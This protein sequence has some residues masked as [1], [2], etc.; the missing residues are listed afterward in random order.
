MART[1]DVFIAGVMA[2]TITH[3]PGGNHRFDY[4][5]VYQD[6]AQRI[7]LSQSLPLTQRR[8]GMRP[9]SNWMWGLLPD[10]E[11]TLD[12]WARR[13]RVSARNPFALLGA[14]GEDCPG[15]VQL[16]H[17]GTGIAAGG[18]VAWITKAGLER[19]I[20]ELLKD[21]G[22]GRLDDDRGQFSLA[23]AQAK[24]ALL[25]EGSRW[26]VPSGRM[27]T[28]HILKPESP[29]F[30]GLAANEHFCLELARAA[31]LPAVR[32]EVLHT[33]NASVFV[34]E[35]YD[36]FRQ[37]GSKTILRLHQ[38][39]C[40]QALGI[41]PQKKYQ[42]EGGPGIPEIMELLRFSKAPETDRGRF[43]R[44]QAFNF[45][46]AGTDAH[47]KNFAILYEPSGAYRLM[48]LYDVI[49]FLPYHTR[50]PQL[51]LAMT[52]GGRRHPSE[53]KPHHWERTAERCGYPA[54]RMQQS[55]RELLETVP[56]LA[57]KV[58]KDC[59]AAGLD[60]AF[61]TRLASLV[62]DHAR[63]LAKGY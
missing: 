61:V 44:A 39:D 4:D 35:R 9:I 36:R 28:T 34:S 54:A 43:M 32:S 16:T 47:A 8:H 10:N 24:T 52:I 12:R 23:G 15:A 63:E 18:D 42:S 3:K 56:D 57:G 20:T 62:A 17:S 25:R 2:G 58:R 19:R 31:G 49:S 45:V 1:L 21:P 13:F 59:V 37:N 27:P 26:G 30:P 55:V 51:K 6:G 5:P 7:P 33:G 40:C 46:I 48:P 60:K 11:I 14:M 22:A 50:T 29:R 41:A 38:E 53:I